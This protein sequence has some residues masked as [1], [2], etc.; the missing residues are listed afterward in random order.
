MV[1]IK[2]TVIICILAVFCARSVHGRS[3]EAP[4]DNDFA[5]FDDFDADDE[6]ESISEHPV[7]TEKQSGGDAYRLWI[8]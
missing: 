8:C 2:A 6:F 1:R 4:E 7:K 5:E 3:D